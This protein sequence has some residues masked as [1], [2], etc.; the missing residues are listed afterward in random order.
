MLKV[1][2]AL[3]LLLVQT[4]SVLI[5]SD[6]TTILDDV[7]ESNQQFVINRFAKQCA[8]SEKYRK[9]AQSFRDYLFQELSKCDYATGQYMTVEGKDGLQLLASFQDG[10]NGLRDHINFIISRS[11]ETSFD[12]NTV[13]S[14][15]DPANF[16]DT[17]AVQQ[18]LEAVHPDLQ[19]YSGKTVAV[20]TDV[21]YVDQQQ[22]NDSISI[23]AKGH[24]LYGM[25]TLPSK[26][27]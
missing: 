24:C 5:A 22:R 16:Q 13:V 21:S 23:Q 2:Q 26:R 6:K 20:V 11:G 10:P 3:V 27:N 18:Y 4:M 15:I 8:V 7:R 17:L 1:H 12:P 19:R 9:V 14:N 25:C